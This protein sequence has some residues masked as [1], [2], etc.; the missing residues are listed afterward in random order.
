MELLDNPDCMKE[1]VILGGEEI[2]TAIVGKIAWWWERQ[3]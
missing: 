2:N 1:A 3:D